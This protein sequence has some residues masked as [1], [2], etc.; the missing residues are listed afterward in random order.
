MDR[1][2][3]LQGVS[4]TEATAAIAASDRERR[5]YFRK[6][7]SIHEEQP[8]QYDLVINTD[9]LTPGR[10]ADIIVHSATGGT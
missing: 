6:F 8:T 1:R 3:F 10:A 4:A 5:D 2:K 7:Y 9:V